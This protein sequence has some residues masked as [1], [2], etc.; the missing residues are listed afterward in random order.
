MTQSTPRPTRQPTRRMALTAALGLAVLASPAAALAQARDAGAEA[1]RPDPRPEGHRVL[2]NKNLSAAQKNASFHHGDRRTGRR[3]AH[4]QFRA[5][6]VRPH[7]HP[8]PAAAVLAAAFRAYAESVYQNRISDYHGETLKVTGSVARKP[9]DVIVNTVDF[10]RPTQPA[11]AGVMA[12]AGRAARGRSSTSS[13]RACGW[14][15][16]SSRTSSRPSTTP[17]ATSAC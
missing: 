9:G 2:A 6:Q 17:A 16:P 14:P 13:S 5:R 11:G 12:R 15:S 4:H 3:A 8:G 7:H 1:V 10:G